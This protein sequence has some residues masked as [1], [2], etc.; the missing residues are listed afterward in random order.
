MGSITPRACGRRAAVAVAPKRGAERGGGCGTTRAPLASPCTGPVGMRKARSPLKPTTSAITGAWPSARTSQIEPTG[1][2]T[3]A[4]S[5][6]SPATRAR[7]PSASSGSMVPACCCMAARKR[8]QR[9]GSPASSGACGCVGAARE[10]ARFMPTPGPPGR[11]RTAAS[12][13]VR[14]AAR[15]ARA[16]ARRCPARGWPLRAPTGFRSMRRRRR[17]PIRRGSRR[18]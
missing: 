15:L 4:A 8:C 3:P 5:S 10:A 14:S 6:T 18:A 7:R 13:P 11:R 16:R 17:G 2:R 12:R 9:A 1:T